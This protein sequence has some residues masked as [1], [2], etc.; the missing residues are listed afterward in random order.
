MQ[1]TEM[2]AA[3]QIGVEMKNLCKATMYRMVKSTGMRVA[4]GL[5]AVAAV[6]YYSCA[7][8]IAEG[9]I[10]ISQAGSIT[11]LGDA[12]MLWLFGALAVSL[13]IG[14]DFE[15]KTIHGAIRFGR[16]KMV[17]NYMLAY[18]VLVTVL[19]LPYTIGSLVCVCSGADFTGAEG[20]VISLYLGN[21]FAYEE[22][23]AGKLVLSY[24]AGLAVYIGQ[25]S[26]CVPV[27]V[28]VKKPVV[29]T[30][31]GFFFG[32]IAALISTLASKV[33]L[34][35]NIYQLTPY[36]YG[37][38]QTGVGAETGDMW[39]GIAVSLVFTALMGVVSWLVLKKADIK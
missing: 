4:V 38:A 30:A 13:L 39:M 24:L 37:M 8:M 34:L 18:L 26:I 23:M 20:T 27:A 1:I 22:G 28:K 12:M 17:L 33:E 3:A 16:R 25:L 9:K 32:M 6:L 31:F 21:V 19:V 10:D 35:D 2:E 5:T 14:S 7:F 11:G 36:R 29:V 15:H